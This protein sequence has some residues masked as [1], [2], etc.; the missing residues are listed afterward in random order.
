[1][2]ELVAAE[3]QGG[4]QDGQPAR[5]LDDRQK[6]LVEA[7]LIGKTDQVA[8]EEAGYRDRHAFAN[9]LRSLGVQAALLE[10][11]RALI[12]GS[13]AAK[14]MA[15]IEGL[16]TNEKTPSATRFAA[17]KWVMEQAGHTT[18]LDDGKDK[19]LH[20]MTEAELAAFMQRA[21]AVVDA[22]GGHPVIAIT[23]DN[24]AE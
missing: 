24:G 19:P 3:P 16:I 15:C 20:E 21:Q 5:Q 14:A 13:M 23:P 8:W 10:A 17:A 6:R 12:G 4:K 11:R 22:G 2:K 1:M 9:A 18:S 7:L